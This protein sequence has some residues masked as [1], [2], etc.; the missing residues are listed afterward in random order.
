[1]LLASLLAAAA[2]PAPDEPSFDCAKAGTRVE[3]MICRDPALAA[4]DRDV[5]I[6]YAKARNRG[7]V[8]GSQAHWLTD[9]DRCENRFCVAAA[10]EKRAEELVD[11][12]ELPLSYDRGGD[13]QAP[14]R[15][16]MAALGGGLHAFALTALW[17]YPGG[18]NANDSAVGGVVRIRAGRGA[19]RDM[20]GCTLTFTRK[21]MGWAVAQGERCS[22]G[23]NVTMGGFYR[24][25]AL[26]PP[27]PPR[28]PSR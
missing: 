24:S 16:R 2:A 9:R 3:I 20:E 14:S 6:L 4:S 5:A 23:L 15:L 11:R 18:V 17:I 7:G 25:R 26:N 1:M 10:Y 21:A 19:W 22:N 13:P 27:L 8:A 12:L 28:G